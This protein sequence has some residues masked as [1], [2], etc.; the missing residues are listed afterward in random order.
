MATEKVEEVSFLKPVEMSLPTDDAPVNY[1]N[2]RV[3]IRVAGD[4]K[5]VDAELGK[6]DIPDEPQALVLTTKQRQLKT[7]TGEGAGTE[8]SAFV[9]PSSGV[10][11]ASKSS[12]PVWEADAPSASEVAKEQ[13]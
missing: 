5:A 1:N 6:L 13:A 12:K 7:Y 4:H 2:E 9:P 3:A 10:F 8:H 11:P